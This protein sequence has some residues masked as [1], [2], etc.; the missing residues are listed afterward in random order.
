M[1]YTKVRTDDIVVED[2]IFNKKDGAFRSILGLEINNEIDDFTF[3][4]GR[5]KVK[6]VNN[7]KLTLEFLINYPN[8]YK[9]IYD[10]DR[11]ILETIV[12]NSKEWFGKESKYET[13]DRLFQRSCVLQSSLTNYPTMEFSIPDAC[14][15][16]DVNDD[17][18][19]LSELEENNEVQCIVNV[20]Q[21]IF[22]QNRFYLDFRM[23]EIHV[24]NYVCQQTECLFS[25]SDE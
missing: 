11:L 4:M 24:V 9:F 18:I 1:K 7:G 10:L 21:I 23:E 25:E 3:E 17:D 14:L 16:K 6:S 22:L 19:T 5:M 13:V 12:D 20:K 8:F 15:I 2:P